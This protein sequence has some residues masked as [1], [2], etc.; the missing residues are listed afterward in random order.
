MPVPDTF[1][2]S[3]MSN[4]VLPNYAKD[5]QG[6]IQHKDSWGKA[7]VGFAVVTGIAIAAHTCISFANIQFQSS[8]LSMGGAAFG[9]GSFLS[10]I[11]STYADKQ[12]NKIAKK[13]KEIIDNINIP[14]TLVDTE[15]GQNPQLSNIYPQS[16]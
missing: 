4:H 16:Q 10:I 2:A 9:I 14:L 15:S 3:V 1:K 7:K 13:T 11:A 6:T 12:Q 8:Y 5:I